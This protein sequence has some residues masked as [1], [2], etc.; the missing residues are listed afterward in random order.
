MGSR[1]PKA[2]QGKK[3]NC[4]HFVYK[5]HVARLAH[6]AEVTAANISDVAETHFLVRAGDEEVRADSRVEWHVAARRSKVQEAER[7]FERALSSVRS[8]VDLFNVLKNLFGIRKVRCHG[9]AKVAHLVRV[10]LALTNP[11][12]YTA[13]GLRLG[14]STGRGPKVG[15]GLDRLALDGP[16]GKHT[17]N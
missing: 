16:V 12:L 3:G 8:R 2:R 14:P 1:D 5:A 7:P 9:L 15:N 4:S 10:A 11:L 13:V 6:T 17:H